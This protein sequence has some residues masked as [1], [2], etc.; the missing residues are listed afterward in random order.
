MMDHSPACYATIVSGSKGDC[1]MHLRG[2]P[3]LVAAQALVKMR[4]EV[5]QRSKPGTPP[6]NTHVASCSGRLMCTI[7][8][9][10]AL[11]YLGLDPYDSEDD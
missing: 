7:A 10:H 2:V 11:V 1:S 5:L 9:R 4:A 3:G 6:Q 8:R